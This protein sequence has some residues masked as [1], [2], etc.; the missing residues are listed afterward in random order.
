MTTTPAGPHHDGDP[1]A[2]VDQILDL[3]AEHYVFPDVGAEI[4]GRLSSRLADGSYDGLDDEALAASVT[5]VLQ[6]V[7]GDLHLRL[8][9]HAEELLDEDD[10]ARDDAEMAAWA[11]STAGGVAR[12]DRLGDVGVLGIAPILFPPAFAAEAVGAA[13]SSLSDASA[14]V[15]DVRECVGGDPE[16]VSFACTYLFGIEA[17]HLNDIVERAGRE[18]RQ[19]WSL[20]YV[21]GTRFGPDKP[22]Y[23]LTSSRTFSGGEELA[24]DLQQLGRAVLVGEHTRGGAHPRRGFRLTAH[25]EVRI[26]VARALNPHSGRNWEGTGVVPDIAVPAEDALDVALRMARDALACPPAATR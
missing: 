23:V 18:I 22:V 14:L 3:L 1:A 19:F 10:D 12:A 7:N 4:A 6:S 11:E 5:D 16:M 2:V 21:P 9:H 24:Y 17:V 8:V 13:F 15:L 26:P 20:P 25:L